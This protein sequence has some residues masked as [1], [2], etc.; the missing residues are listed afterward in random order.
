M[1]TIHLSTDDGRNARVPLLRPRRLRPS[2]MK[3]TAFGEEVV[4]R[5]VHRGNARVHVETLTAQALIDGDP[6]IDLDNIGRV[7]PETTRAY[8]RPGGTALEGNFQVI[9]TTYAPDGTER[10]RAV[11]TP[12]KANINELAPVRMGRR[13]PLPELFQRF[14]FNNQLHLGH[15][16]GLQ[17]EFLLAIARRLEAAGEA[18]MLGAGPKGNQPL[19]LQNGGTPTRAFLV[20][21]TDGDKYRLR[22]LLTRQELKVPEARAATA[23][24]T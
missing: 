14:A 20:G 1:N 7:L 11:H 3:V 6:E 10:D 2:T 24:A 22:V 13:I 19:V 5:T 12:R 8:L 18:A 15:E 17:H 9:V 21:E 4:S 16:D 23:S